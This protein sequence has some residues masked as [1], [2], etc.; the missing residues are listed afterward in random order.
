MIGRLLAIEQLSSRRDRESVA[1]L[2]N[3]LNNDPF[4]GVRLEA[5][6]RSAPSIPRNR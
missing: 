4:Y 5:A 6:K 3:A 2:R 1:L